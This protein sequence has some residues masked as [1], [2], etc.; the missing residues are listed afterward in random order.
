MPALSATVFHAKGTGAPA[1]AA[2][3]PPRGGKSAYAWP[4]L[5]HGGVPGETNMLKQ[6]PYF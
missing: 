6:F 5:G 2:L 4:R 3:P 1:S